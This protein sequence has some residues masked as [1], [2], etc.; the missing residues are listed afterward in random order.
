MTS[1]E[2]ICIVA[3]RDVPP[4]HPKTQ[5]VQVG[6]YIAVMSAVA[7]PA[8]LLP[9]SRTAALKDAAA[10][11]AI[12]EGLLPHGTVLVARPDQWVSHTE[13]E[14]FLRCNA[15]QLDKIAA[16][17]EGKWQF[18]ITISWD[19]AQ[20]MDRFRDTPELAPLFAQKS[21]SPG[22]LEAALDRLRAGLVARISD[23][24]DPVVSDLIRLPCAD[25]MLANL[26]V[27]VPQRA[28]AQLDH[29]VQAIDDIWTE[30]LKIK[31][32]GP[33]AAGSFALLDLQWIT[34]D[35]IKA[36]HARLS[37][38]APATIEALQSARRRALMASQ[39]DTS[40]I[41]EAARII[42]A[43][44]GAAGQGFHLLSVLSEDQGVATNTWMDVA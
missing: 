29:C 11:Q 4:V 22:Q 38:P 15:A 21:A 25:D 20:V 33:S 39:G 24:L 31:Q 14:V 36:A 9:R 37:L 23:I 26:V 1:H 19:Q 2:L 10:R 28:E 30:G 43:S 3:G 42:A 12:I 44:A 5:Y 34:D 32:I 17:L 7:R 18:Q 16:S 6:G 27:L 13:A 8:I 41:R 40:D 35:Q